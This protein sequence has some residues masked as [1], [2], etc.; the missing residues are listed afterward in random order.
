MG[1]ILIIIGALLLGMAFSV[2]G[3]NVRF[4]SGSIGSLFLAMGIAAFVTEVV[5]KNTEEIVAALKK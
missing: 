1:G 2:P 5:E 4:L 3:I